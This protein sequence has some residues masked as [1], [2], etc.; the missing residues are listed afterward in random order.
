MYQLAQERHFFRLFSREEL[1]RISTYFGHHAY[2]AGKVVSEPAAPLKMLGVILSGELI[3]EEQGGLKGHWITLF[4]MRRGAIVMHPSL[5]DVEPPAMRGLAGQ[6]LTVM[7]MDGDA[8]EKMLNEE[9]QVGIKFMRE[10]VR[11]SLIRSLSMAERL[12]SVF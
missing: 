6:D 10:L 3:I 2:P 7:A 12:I 1:S 8:F 4:R 9:S 5:F 11:V